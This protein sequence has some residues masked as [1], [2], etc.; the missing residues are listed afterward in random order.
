MNTSRFILHSFLVGLLCSFTFSA[1]SQFITI[2]RKIKTMHTQESDVATVLL[3]AKTYKV[4]QA[5]IDTLGSDKK[6]RITSTDPVKRLVVFTEGSSKVTM[7]VDSLGQGM[8]QITV[9]ATHPDTPDA[10]VSNKA[11][12]AIMNVCRKAGIRCSIE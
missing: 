1:H 4:Y 9:S 11:V 10:K 8:T 6:F 5:V 7:Q 12:Q 3:D 2:A